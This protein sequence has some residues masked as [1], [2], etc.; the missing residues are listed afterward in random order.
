MAQLGEVIGKIAK[1]HKVRILQPFTETLLPLALHLMVR[2]HE[3][4]GLQ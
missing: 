3:C 1:I 4:I 2:P